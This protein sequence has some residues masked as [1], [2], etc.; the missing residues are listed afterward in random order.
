MQYLNKAGTIII[1]GIAMLNYETNFI[2]TLEILNFIYHN[3]IKW[4]D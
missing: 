4:S 3:F 1:V 2:F